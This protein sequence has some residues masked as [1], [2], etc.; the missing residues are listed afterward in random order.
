MSLYEEIAQAVASGD[1][2]KATELCQTM[3]EA[4]H[5]P[6]EI[7]SRGYV[8]GMDMVELDYRQGKKY[9]PEILMSARVINKGMD[10]IASYLGD[11]ALT[12]LDRV[13]IGTVKGDIHD[14]GKQLVKMMLE[15][16]G[17]DV[18]DLGTDVTKEEFIKGIRQAEASVV[19]ISAMLT[20]TMSNMKEVVEAIRQT[21]FDQPV[22]ILVG[23]NPVTS[24]FARE[25]NAVFVDSAVEAKDTVMGI[26]QNNR[27]EEG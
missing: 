2:G 10:K 16:A 17:F 11:R 6:V 9:I 8:P 4:G 24:Q 13:V 15:S 1:E 19:L 12:R 14:I 26:Y 18:L 20:T 25:I 3:L 7:I 27:G 21:N 23:G 5:N 22:T